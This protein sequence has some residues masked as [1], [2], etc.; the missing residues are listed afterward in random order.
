MVPLFLWFKKNPHR[1][2]SIAIVV[3]NGVLLFDFWINFIASLD[4]ESGPVLVGL[5]FITPLFI[6]VLNLLL[7]AG[8]KLVEAIIERFRIVSRE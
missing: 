7:F 5:F 6:P 1:I 4:D 3:V 2:F 8:Y